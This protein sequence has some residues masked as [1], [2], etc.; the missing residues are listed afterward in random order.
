MNRL[1]LTFALLLV[2]ILPAPAEDRGDKVYGSMKTRWAAQV[3]AAKPLPDHPRPQ[4]ARP[5]WSNL[6]G[7]WDYAISKKDAAMPKTWEGKITVPFCVESQLSGVQ[8][9]VGPD[10]RLWYHRSFP[11]PELKPGQRA[12]L[13]FGAV[14]WEALIYVNGSIVTL[15]RGGYTPFHLDITD[16]LTK[17]PTQE[18]TVSVWDPTDAGSQPRG[19][20]SASPK[21]IFY[22]AV[23]GIWQTVWL[24]I[25]PRSHISDLRFTPKIDS[26]EITIFAEIRGQA[27]FRALEVIAYDGKQE[28]A[29]GEAYYH[30]KKA[31]F[32]TTL[33]I[34][35]PK[36]WSPDSPHLYFLKLRLANDD[37]ST[38]DA[39][40]S[41]FAMR[42]VSLVADA[43]GTPRI[44]LNNQ[45]TFLLGPLDQGWWPDGLYTAPT[46]EALRSD[47]EATKAMGFNVARKH[48]KVEPARWYYWADRLGLLVWQDMPSGNAGG[49]PIL[50]A[51]AT[52]DPTDAKQFKTELDDVIDHL[53]NHPC[54]IIWTIFNEGWGQHD[55]SHLIGWLEKRDPTRL[56]GGPSG[57]Q[58]HGA[59]QLL[60]I[61]RYPGPS[62]PAPDGQ[63]KRALVLSEFGG[64]KLPSPATHLWRDKDNWGYVAARDQSDLRGR[65]TTLRDELQALI[66]AGLSAAIYTQTTD[67]ETEINGLLSYDRQ[68]N[69]PGAEWIAETNAPLYKIPPASK[70]SVLLNT[71]STWSFTTA[72]PAEN[73]A[74][75]DF[76]DSTWK[77]AAA[78]FGDPAAKAKTAWTSDHLWV[79]Q[80]FDLADAKIHDLMLKIH[81]NDRARVYLNGKLVRDCGGHSPTYRLT[82]LGEH[83][84][85]ALVPGKN[86]IAIE[87]ENEKHPHFLDAG[88]INYRL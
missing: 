28:I 27:D 76:D 35:E 51:E 16:F 5:G 57:W 71:G 80:T 55:S 7:Q 81:N 3:D 43:A 26:G 47:I 11:T 45:A 58:D 37:G 4:M 70:P 19:K 83:G 33:K 60:D 78:P 10:Q 66:R 52:A 13:H 72:R 68:I 25:V 18:I 23:T 74:A 12:K 1:Q 75:P 30:Y 62:M 48:V 87:I 73:W 22:T 17:S 82:P 8:R 63:A 36:L 24:E 15:H 9:S 85:K 41:Y 39:V 50:G 14:D 38:H 49:N 65:Y 59:G 6:N 64:L 67:V 46:D 53:E 20:Q 69:K 34:P 31:G 21:G 88:L 29:R 40:L 61:H 42:K 77:Q 2:S 86:T 56:S 54:V 32:E 79:R 84:A 44:A